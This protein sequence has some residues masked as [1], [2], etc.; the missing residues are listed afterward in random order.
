[1]QTIH[2]IS[3]KEILLFN[4]IIVTDKREIKLIDSFF[5]FG[6]PKNVAGSIPVGDAN[7]VDK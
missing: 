2:Y 3:I 6:F 1:M 4:E 7:F 5:C